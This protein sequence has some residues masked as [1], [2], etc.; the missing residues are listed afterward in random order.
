M[1]LLQAVN[2]AKSFGSHTVLDGLS[3][4]APAGSMVA[5]TGPSGSGKSTL[6]NIIGLLEAPTSGQVTFGE[7]GTDRALGPGGDPLPPV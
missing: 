6:L 2:L 4:T 1:A 3:F 5:V 7:Y